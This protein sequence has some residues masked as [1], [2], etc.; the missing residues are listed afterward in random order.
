MTIVFLT[1]GM[2]V[3]VMLGWLALA[4]IEGAHPVLGRLERAAWS[5]ALGPTV[6]LLAVTLTHWAG[7]IR[8]DLPGFCMV[9]GVLAVAL[10]AVGVRTG[11][12]RAAW[13]LQ[14][15]QYPNA[16]VSRGAMVGIG[17]LIAWTCIKLV[18]GGYNLLTVPTYWDDSFN[19]WNMRGKMFYVQHELVLNIPV[20]NGT[21]QTEGGVSSYPPTVPLMKTWLALLRGSWDEPLVNGVHMVWLLGL[22]A[23]AYCLLRRRVSGAASAMGT[24]ALASLPLLLI[25]GANPYADV[26]VAAHVL[27]AAG[28]LYEST[29]TTG[30][31]RSSWIR[32][33]GIAIG[34]LTFTKN[35]GMLLYAP[36]LG[37]L[38]C[39]ASVRKQPSEYRQSF[40]KALALAAAITLP[41]L[42]FKWTHG[43]TF[44]NAKGV[45]DVTIAFS[46]LAAHA[47]WFH[48]THEPNWMLLPL[49]VPVCMA[50]AGR[51]ARNVLSAFV[52]IVFAEQC[53]VFTCT[54]LANEAIMQTGISRGLLHIAPV[55]V[56]LC[57]IL[58]AQEA[59]RRL[60]ANA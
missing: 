17:I 57:T 11:A 29:M 51:S 58:L 41:W 34:L 16:S 60:G 30:T 31:Q 39:Y 59:R 35:E 49:L 26:F 50:Y 23:T 44:G 24:C 12:L 21:V 6:F 10:I 42:V 38:L 54:S 15:A 45:T 1:I 36:V 27:V 55:T 14:P 19:N 25:H 48:L 43:L 4:C 5:M 18:A 9:A 33:C 53:I 32:L 8:L 28:S 37:A 20:G 2:A 22:L 7:L 46:P 52:V 3:P 56:V 40:A 13:R 47:I